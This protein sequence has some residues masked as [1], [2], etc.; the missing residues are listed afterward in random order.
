MKGSYWYNI[1]V[2]HKKL[3]FSTIQNI[4]L[5]LVNNFDKVNML[6]ITLSTDAGQSRTSKL[7]LFT[8]CPNINVSLELPIWLLNGIS[9]N[10]AF[11]NFWV[12]PIHLIKNSPIMKIF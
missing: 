10:V 4:K 11:Y 8:I 6:E 7:F 1:E 3:S 5:S 9:K 12:L 2:F